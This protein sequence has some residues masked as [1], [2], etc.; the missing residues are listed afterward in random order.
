MYN[1][2]HVFEKQKFHL[3]LMTNLLTRENIQCNVSQTRKHYG[4]E[5]SVR[6]SN[7]LIANL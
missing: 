6:G 7:S 5:S 4:I 3:R 2:I 1:E